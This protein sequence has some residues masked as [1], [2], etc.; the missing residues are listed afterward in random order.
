MK[1]LKI[2]VANEAES[3][4]AQE[5]F[6]ELGYSWKIK[7]REKD[8]LNIGSFTHLTTFDKYIGQGFGSVDHK[9]ITLPELRDMVVL[10]RNDKNDRNAIDPEYDRANLYLD[11][12]NDLFVFHLPTQKWKESSLNNE[13]EVLAR[14]QPIEKKESLNDKVASA[15]AYRQAEV[16]PF[17][18]DEPLTNAE[19]YPHYFKSVK[20]LDEVDV[21]AVMD[22]FDVQNQA[23]GHAV[24]KLLVGGKRG[25]KNYLRDIIEARDT[26]NRAIQI[27]EKKN[28]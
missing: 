25:A 20:H 18:D 26:L 1:N 15:E 5:L 19:K 6:F 14:L 11:S 2:R 4:E 9:K 3:R 27:L 8:Y 22:L 12:K 17:I 28:G 10:K 21:Y 23:V 24:K 13:P 16:L 7:G